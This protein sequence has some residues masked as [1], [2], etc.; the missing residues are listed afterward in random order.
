MHW[1]DYLATLSD[2]EIA[3]DAAKFDSRI[4]PPLEDDEFIE[5][6]F[7]DFLEQCREQQRDADPQ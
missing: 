4:F 3:A 7:A 2:A 1:I 5:S 6:S